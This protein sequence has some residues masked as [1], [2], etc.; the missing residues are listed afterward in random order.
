MSGDQTRCRR[1]AAPV[2]ADDRFCESCGSSLAVLA[3]ACVPSRPDSREGACKDCGSESFADGYCAVCGNLHT[4]P[5]RDEAGV[6]GIALITDR[7]IGHPRNEDSAAAGVTGPTGQRGSAMAV[8]VCD[9]VSASPA[10][11]L[12]A[13]AASSAG[14]DAMLAALTACRTG[15]A[16]VLAGLASAAEAAARTGGADPD[17]APSCTYTGAVVVASD[18][19]SVRISVGNVGDSRAYWLPDPPGTA[20]Q[21]TSDDS[22]AQELITAG[23]HTDS[24]AVLAGAHVLT[25]WLG[26]DAESTPWPESSVHTIVATEPG[27]LVLCT[28]GLWNYLP[29]A[30]DI[31]RF[32]TGVDAFA[33]ARAL[34]DHALS[35]GG[36]DNITVAVVPIGGHHEFS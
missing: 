23:A 13:T 8:A 31:A 14:V 2:T 12:A 11:H 28:D 34:V 7:G 3:Q 29:G 36:H 4:G 21:L 19:G 35:A 30:D 24:D 16:A 22:V 6:G 17:T 15:P 9:G 5:D 1:C 26:G 25:R 27:A 10:A 33:A 32:C 18:D 20:E